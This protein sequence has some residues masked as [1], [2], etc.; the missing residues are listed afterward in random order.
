MT[1]AQN[2]V[3]FTC[4]WS[5]FISLKFKVVSFPRQNQSFLTHQLMMVCHSDLC[6]CTLRPYE[7]TY[8]RCHGTVWIISQGLST[9]T[10]KRQATYLFFVGMQKLLCWPRVQGINVF[11]LQ[12]YK[13]WMHP[14]SKLFL[15]SSP[16]IKI[17]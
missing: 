5:L 11:I 17:L 4:Y 7:T 9:F 10:S 12:M 16:R 15:P 8:E 14:I 13:H 6:W 1:G 2:S 3:L